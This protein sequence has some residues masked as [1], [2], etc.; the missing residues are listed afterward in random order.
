M[1]PDVRCPNGSLTNIHEAALISVTN[2]LYKPKL[3]HRLSVVLVWRQQTV[4]GQEYLYMDCVVECLC[5][6][7]QNSK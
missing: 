4:Q 1:V 7:A 2:Q 5:Y 6:S 3:P